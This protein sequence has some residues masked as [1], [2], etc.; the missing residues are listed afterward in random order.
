MFLTV[1]STLKENNRVSHIIL[2]RTKIGIF[3][4]KKK[5]SNHLMIKKIVKGSS[6]MLWYFDVKSFE[7]IQYA[8]GYSVLEWRDFNTSKCRNDFYFQSL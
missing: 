1:V 3:R 6:S 2:D 5:I 7:I 4:T 8:M